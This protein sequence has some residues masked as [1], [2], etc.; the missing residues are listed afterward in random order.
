MVNPRTIHD[1]GGFPQILYE[2][3]YLAPGNPELAKET[4]QL[5][6]KTD[7]KLDEKWGLDHGAWSVIRHMYPD[8]DI[9][10]IQ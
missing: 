9:P 2:V 7:V 3:Q 10:V 5:I 1:F 8:A 4:R 6:K